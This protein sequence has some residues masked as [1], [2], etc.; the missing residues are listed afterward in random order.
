[1]VEWTQKP[2]KEKNRPFNTAKT[3]KHSSPK[4][5]TLT[6]VDHLHGTR[7]DQGWQMVNRIRECTNVQ[8]FEPWFTLNRPY[9]THDKPE[10]A[11]PYRKIFKIS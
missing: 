4:T 8:K 6:T 11:H 10:N 1:M 9:E 2:N 7:H 5:W 3:S